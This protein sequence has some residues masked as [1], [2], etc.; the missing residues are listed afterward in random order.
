MESVTE[1]QILLELT[2]EL[3]AVEYREVVSF[4]LMRLIY[5]NVANE[6]PRFLLKPSFVKGFYIE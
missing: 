6:T 3:V 5:N 4:C 2:P 1:I